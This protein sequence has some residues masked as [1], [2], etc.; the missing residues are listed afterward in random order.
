M[1]GQSVDLVPTALVGQAGEKVRP[2]RERRRKRGDDERRERRKK[3]PNPWVKLLHM[4]VAAA[5]KER[6]E[7]PDL[8]MEGILAW[9]DAY[10]ARTSR[11]PS[12]EVGEIPEAPG[13]TWLLVDAAL[14]LGD[15]GCGGGTTLPRFL[16]EQW[17][18]IPPEPPDF[19]VAQILAWADAFYERTGR[20][21][22]TRSGEIPGTRGITW[23]MVD[24]ALRAGRTDRPSGLSLSRLL[25]GMGRSDRHQ[26][27]PPLTED[28]ILA[29]ADAHYERTGSWPIADSGWIVGAPGEA[30]SHIEYALNEGARGLAGGS[31]L[32]RL[33]LARRGVRPHHGLP[34]LDVERILVWADAHHARTGGWPTNRS[35]PIPEAHGET[36]EAVDA[37]LTHGRRTLPVGRTLMGLLVDRRGVRQRDYLPRLSVPE[38]LAWADAFYDRSGRWPSSESG[39]VAE[40]PGETWGTIDVALSGGCRG[41]PGGSSLARL[42]AR[43]RGMRNRMDLRPLSI[44]EILRWADAHRERHGTWPSSRSGPIPEAPGETWLGVDSALGRGGRGLAGDSSVARLLAAERGVRNYRSAVPPLTEGQIL[45][46]A[47]V[48]HARAGRWPTRKSGPIPEAPGETWSGVV[49]A[50][51]RGRRGL[52]RGSSLARLLARERRADRSSGRSLAHTTVEDGR[53]TRIADRSSANGSGS[54]SR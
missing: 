4:A 27:K 40:A 39:A 50:L 23:K 36:W 45:A 17:V 7:L 11:W 48:H 9:A 30:W 6:G 15:R 1:A 31:A 34:P 16:A 18:R 32:C 3:K 52:P 54:P 41:L 25:T 33:L 21:P 42:L 24:D 53:G 44:P 13:E 8:S 2:R 28:Q 14:Y 49:T 5:R 37:A 51:L 29:W 22:I 43:E 46:W 47:D 10:H 12:K 19:T 35:G 26:E 38:I 20:R